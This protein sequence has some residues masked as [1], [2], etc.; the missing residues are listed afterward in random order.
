MKSDCPL[1]TECGCPWD[2]QAQDLL[3]WFPPRA[4]AGAL[5]KGQCFPPHTWD[6]GR[7]SQLKYRTTEMS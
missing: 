2:S 7:T 3:P 4:Q 5:E 6:K 1:A